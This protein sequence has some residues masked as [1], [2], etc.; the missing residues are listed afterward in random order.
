MRVCYLHLGLAKTGSTAIQQALGGHE[1]DRLVYPINPDTPRPNHTNM[2]MARICASPMTHPN[3]RK[4]APTKAELAARIE[5]LQGDF[6][7]ALSGEKDVILS[8]E[9]IAARLTPAELRAFA[10]CLRGRFACIRPIVYIRPVASLTASGFQEGVK[11]GRNHYEAAG[12][13]FRKRLEPIVDAFA[14]EEIEFVRFDRAA[15]SNGDVVE[16]FT[17]RVGIAHA[18]RNTVP[19]NPSLSAEATGALYAFN[20]FVAPNLPKKARFKT[21][22]ALA[23]KLTGQG[24]TRF[25]FSEAFMRR[26]IEA[27]EEDIAWAEQVAGFDLR[28]TVEPVAHPV[29]TEQDLLALARHAPASG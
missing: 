20:C 25:G 26:H 2:V 8:G 27:H 1:D 11:N 19:V 17:E 18:P 15:F 14:S 29:D 24:T 12:P 3:F 22:K 10:E 7:A 5:R 21:R 4:A 23:R 28:G 6:D 16:D 13:R 9:G